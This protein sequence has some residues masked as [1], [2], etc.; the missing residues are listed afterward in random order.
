VNYYGV[1]PTP[2][3]PHATQLVLS[4]LWQHLGMEDSVC[5]KRL[6]ARC[7]PPSSWPRVVRRG[8]GRTSSLMRDSGSSPSSFL[9]SVY[10]LSH[11]SLACIFLT[12]GSRFSAAAELIMS[13]VVLNLP[14]GSLSK[15]S[16]TALND[17]SWMVKFPAWI[18]GSFLP[19]SRL[20]LLRTTLNFSKEVLH[21]KT[22]RKDFLL[23][24]KD[25]KL[26]LFF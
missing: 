11:W 13:M 1:D 2:W 24:A 9:K 26:P 6:N 8:G 16:L 23:L 14:E 3:S 20:F 15:L 10:A 21:E 12:L 25:R 4:C 18:I 5:H 17:S 7:Q 22:F 19:L